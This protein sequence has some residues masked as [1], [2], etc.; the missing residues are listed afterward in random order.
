FLDDDALGGLLR[1]FRQH[2]RRKGFRFGFGEGGADL[3]FH[4]LSFQVP[5]DDT[6]Q[7]VRRIFLFIVAEDVFALHLIIDVRIADDRETIRAFRV[8]GLE[9]TTSGAL[10]G[11]ILIL[12]HRA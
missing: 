8:G 5:D 6:E 10:A 3:F 11:I 1:F 4:L 12:V 2:R 9:Q 7:I